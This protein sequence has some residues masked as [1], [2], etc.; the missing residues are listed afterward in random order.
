MN[1]SLKKPL[2]EP[3]IPYASDDG[4]W[5]AF[6]EAVARTPKGM[7]VPM[8]IGGE[9]VRAKER[10]ESI[11]PSTGEVFCTAQK[12][13]ADHAKAA[14]EAALKAKESW[15]ALP[16]EYR[17]QK[18]R[19]LEAILLDRRH[20]LCA[21]TAQECG[22]IA[23][24]VSGGWAEMIDFIRFNPWYY[25]QLLRTDLGDGDRETNT[26]RLRALKG[27]TCA[28]TPFNFPIAI[29]YNLPTVMALTGNTVVWKPSSDAP[30]TSW[31]LMRAIQ[32]AGFPPGVINMIT[33]PGST[34]MPPVLKHPE[35]NCVNF[36]GGFDTA[37]MIADELFAKETPR[38]HF[39]RFVAET[40]GKDFLVADRNCDP[41]D[42]A[43]CIIAGAF[44][45]SGQKCSA[46]SLV[47]AD[48]KVWPEIKAAIVEQMGAFKTGNPLER[49]TQM[50][51]VINRGA[52]ET[53]TGFIKRGKSDSKVRLLWGGE[54]S[55]EKGFFIQPTIFEV[56]ADRHEL[57]SV[58]IF[59][60]VVAVKV[61][62]RIEEA[63]E[64]IR[65]NTYRLTGSVW[66]SDEQFLARWVPVLS[67]FAGN[68]YVNRKTT[69]AIVDQQPFGGDG[70]SGTNFKAGGI[71]Y[72]LSFISQGTVTRRH[73]RFHR[74]PGI[75]NWV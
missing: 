66:S 54:F 74:H 36:T 43:A 40:G 64:I 16:P 49:A 65:N 45:R 33:G 53:I 62:D 48:R 27:F 72:L 35:I 18:F 15:A 59:G 70:A 41:W 5:K 23:P 28:I 6:Q 25:F 67:E 37:R 10:I 63:V 12:A 75:W 47:L 2:N 60:P 34:T 21:V 8:I 20:E 61:Y 4:Q 26:L 51:P 69:G 68:F 52:Y 32:D 39:P 42:V 38:P 11:D 1:L 71:W 17:I 55:D 58:E 24:E 7:D 73:G 13:T 22:Y 31:M 29:G 30:M 9:E 3:L 44:G 19:D 14:I 57:L 46:N 56:E 50:G